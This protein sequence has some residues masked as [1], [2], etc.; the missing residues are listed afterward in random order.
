MRYEEIINLLDRGFTPDQITALTGAA[1]P[2][3]EP[4]PEEQEPDPEPAPADPEPAPA[5]P[6]PAPADPEPDPEIS[7][8]NGEIENL[9]KQL[10]AQNIKTQ[11]VSILP[12]DRETVESVLATIIRPPFEHKDNNK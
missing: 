1:A 9:K 4:A 12:G 3:P 10:Q 6:E 5:D 7:R 8:L 2:D 11:S